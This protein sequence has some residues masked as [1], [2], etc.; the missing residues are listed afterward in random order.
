M[1]Y[2]AALSAVEMANWDIKTIDLIVLAT[3]TPHDLFGS[4]P[5][6]QAKLGAPNLACIDGAEPNKSW[7]VEV[8]RTIKSIVLISQLAISTADNAAL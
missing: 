6:I 5:S 3:S 1:G 4:A 7:G 8:A 2:K